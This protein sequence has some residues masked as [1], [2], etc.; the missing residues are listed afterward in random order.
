MIEFNPSTITKDSELQDI[1]MEGYLHTKVFAKVF[2]PEIFELPFSSLHDKIFDAIDSPDPQV[3]IA[4]PRGLGKTSIARVYATKKIVYRDS[5]FITY[6]S[7]S[8][9]SAEMQTENIKDNLRACRL[10][11]ELFGDIK[12]S[13]YGNS[14]QF[15]KKTW[16]ANGYT[17]VLPRGSGQQVRGLNWLRYRPDIFVLDDLEDPLTIDNETIR[18]DRKIWFF[19]DVMKAKPIGGKPYKIIYIDTVKHEDA[20][21]EGLLDSDGWT[22]LR[23]SICDDNYRTLAPEF[24]SQVELDA[25]LADH[26]KRHIMDVFA[27]ENQSIPISKEAA[28]F[29]SE[30]FQYYKETDADFVKRIPFIENVVIAD[31]SKTSNP[32]NAQSGIIV[33]GVDVETNALYLR[34][35]RGEY[36]HP[37]QL[38]DDIFT[39]ALRYN[40]RVIGLEVTGLNEFITYPFTNEMIRRGHSFEIVELKAR[41]GEGEFAGVGGGKKGRIA[42]LIPL[43]RQG[44]IYHNE[45]GCGPYEK[46]LLGFP[47]SKLWDIMD[48][49]AYIVEILEKGLRYFMPRDE[50]LDSERVVKKEY[51][52]LERMEEFEYDPLLYDDVCP[53]TSS[54]I[55][56]TY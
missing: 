10:L 36:Y 30:F 40:A 37:E 24:K 14:E 27:R 34:E 54:G 12:T 3:V 15:S 1:L 35:A 9:T 11:T 7:N 33:W 25:E 41:K 46:Q 22:S 50:D 18:N 6:L 21:I 26:R 53:G 20:L 38:Y 32:A 39:T 56:D 55:G 43:Y 45:V 29:K 17:M 42:S 19:A 5:R 52:D 44:L 49:A 8:A 4:A 16:I 51:K 13:P 2:F 47:K 28:S 23:L 48:G 31:P